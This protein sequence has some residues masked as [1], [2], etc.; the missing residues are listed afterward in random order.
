[1]TY[2]SSS[3]GSAFVLSKVIPGEVE[4]EVDVDGIDERL[5]VGNGVI[6]DGGGAVA[7][8]SSPPFLL[9]LAPDCVI[10]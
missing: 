6:G 2:L 1:M 9:I 5:F 4:V 3:S 8:A 7:M 10:V